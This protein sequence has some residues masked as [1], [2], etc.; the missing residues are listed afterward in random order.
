[1][2]DVV[3]WSNLKSVQD[4]QIKIISKV[5]EQNRETILHLK[6]LTAELDRATRR[7]EEQLHPKPASQKVK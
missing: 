4:D 6:K 2:Q 7:T 5:V 1:L 3:T